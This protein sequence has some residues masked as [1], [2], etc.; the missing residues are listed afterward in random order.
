MIVSSAVGE[1]IEVG[2]SPWYSQS[3]N[4]NLRLYDRY[5]YDYATLYRTQP[6]VRT[7]VDFLARN[8][9]QLGLHVFRRVSDTDRVRLTDHPLARLIA[10]PNSWTTRYR[11]IEALMGDLG[12][13]FNAYWL[14]LA[15]DDNQMWLLR[16]P[17]QLMTVRGG[18]APVEYE[19]DASIRRQKFSPSE[20][21]HFRG[22][23][24]E[25]A[26]VGLSPLE[27]LRRI[28]AEE[29]AMG[30]YRENFWRNSARMY[31]VVER[32]LGAPEW[33]P[34]SRE[35]FKAEFEALYAGDENSGRTAVLEEGMTWKEASFSAQESE[36]FA[37]RKLTREECARAYHIPLP[38]VGI[39]DNAT[40]SNISEQ[41]KNL[42]QDSLGPWLAM[43]SEEIDLQLSGDFPDADGVYCE[44]N[45]RE[46]M[47]G[48]FE[49]QA[50]SFQ[51]LVGRPVMTANEARAR[52]NLPS[53]GGDADAL[54]TPMNVLIGGQASPQDSAPKHLALEAAEE[55]GDGTHSHK[56]A[57]ALIKGKID[58][59]H[60]ELRARHEDKWRRLMENTFR[61]Q[62]DAVIGYA[63]SATPIDVWWDAER[64]NK[65][66]KTDFYVMNVA[67][68]TAFARRVAEMLEFELDEAVMEPWLLEN[69]GWSAQHI[70]ETTKAQIA[71]VL[72]DKDPVVSVKNVFEVAIA[73][74]AA[75]I[76]TSKVTTAASFGTQ[77]AAKQGGLKSKTWQVNSANPRPEHLAMNGETVGIRELFS[78][79]ML[80]P[81]DPAGGAENNANCMCSV[82]FS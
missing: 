69:A 2:T 77:E 7:C 30:N 61:R 9:A 19:I 33:R 46:K 16:V 22:Y 53:L 3:A 58:P 5:Y 51:A 21:V 45:I 27:T 32:P 79:G 36:Y 67:T 42:Y 78:N 28:L 25:S 37:G 71:A 43:I 73:A 18:L 13:Y 65:E 60:P 81:G 12:V 20:V 40:F 15:R 31:G 47:E 74:R 4:R 66:L 26:T 52:M 49:E 62:R 54:V 76:A 29:H 11:L 57:V 39:L 8:V 72:L 75:Q 82:T 38:M 35:R 34:D 63:G 59:M 14:K 10:R 1:L 44:F 17:P 55:S 50:K 56:H 6:N 68:A 80:W 23:N 64:W 48:S 24:P 70:N 41:H